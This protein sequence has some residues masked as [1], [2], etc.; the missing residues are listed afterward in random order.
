M[1]RALPKD[2]A[3][4]ATKVERGYSPPAVRS[5]PSATDKLLR[6]ISTTLET[7]PVMIAAA[8]KPPVVNVPA[9][10]VNVEAAK[11]AD[12]KIN[13]APVY[14]STPEIKMPPHPTIQMPEQRA[15]VV[16]VEPPDVHLTIN[17]PKEWIFD[18]KR[19]EYGQMMT[20]HAKAI[21]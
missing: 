11:P 6:E 18:I 5:Q 2:Q 1:A 15:P 20:I 8:I 21:L 12:V 17:R 9:P 4:G 7:L 3:N 13:Q 10:V 19:N 14:V 16:N